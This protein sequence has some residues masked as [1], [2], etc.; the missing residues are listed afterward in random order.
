M[1]GSLPEKIAI[2]FVFI[3]TL[4]AAGV[5]ESFETETTGFPTVIAGKLVE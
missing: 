3:G 2:R 4:T 1:I 5:E